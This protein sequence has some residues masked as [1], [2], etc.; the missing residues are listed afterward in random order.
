M[1]NSPESTGQHPHRKRI[2]REREILRSSLTLSGD[3]YSAFE[4]ARNEIL[5]WARKRSGETLPDYAWNGKSF[6]SFSG[7]R[8]TVGASIQGTD[9]T[10]WALRGD[11]PDKEVPGR[12]WTTEVSLG[13]RDGEPIRLSL[14]QLVN[15]HEDELDISPH[16]PGLLLQ[17]SDQ[18]GLYSGTYPITQA[19]KIIRSDAD[20]ENLSAFIEN[21]Q[22]RL[23]IIICTGDER[24][25]SPD[26]PLINT[27]DLSRATLGLAHTFEVPSKYTYRLSDRLGRLRSVYHGGAR[28]YLPGFEIFSSPYEHPL[29]LGE[30]LKKDPEGIARKLALLVANQSLFRTHLGRDVL[31]FLA[32]RS[33]ALKLEQDRRKT[34]GATDADQLETAV[35]RISALEAEL[36]TSKSQTEQALEEAVRHED[37]ANIAEQSLF[38]ARL[39]IQSLEHSLSSSGID[40][41]KDTPLPEEWKDFSDWC[42]RELAGRVVLTAGARK[43]TKKP[44]FSNPRLA[45]KA[46]LWLASE[47]RTRRIDGG[48][49]LANIPISDGLE[50]APCGNDTF[51]FTFDGRALEAE[52]HVKSGGNTRHPSRCLRIYFAFDHVTLQIVVADMPAHRKTSAS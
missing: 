33:S 27:R 16:V 14:R 13:W 18:C 24:S 28:I 42:D 29:F 11:D 50:C 43:S 48:G 3:T 6:E 36:A 12:I 25:P 34:E 40:P 1:R 46:L 51:T 8:T 22:R 10:L 52:W 45:G 39:R 4:Q 32:I 5:T 17:I 23:P 47:F 37:R 30:E 41:D 15:S 31:S 2:I 9:I 19:P 26:A 21:P 49:T 35:K 44:E 20:F 7:G 38:G